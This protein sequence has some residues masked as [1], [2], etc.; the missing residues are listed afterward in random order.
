MLEGRR[1][2]A[3]PFIPT[4]TRVPDK[5][6]C[7]WKEGR[8]P[9]RWS[10]SPA[11]PMPGCCDHDKQLCSAGRKVAAGGLEQLQQQLRAG[12]VVASYVVCLAICIASV[13]LQVDRKSAA[14]L[15]QPLSRAGAFVSE[16]RLR[17]EY[18]QFR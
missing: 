11:P 9:H 16:D 1:C 2:I 13:S 8:T 18:A 10:A 17:K 4:T 5:Q 15:F 12:F 14:H 3:S 7:C 6:L